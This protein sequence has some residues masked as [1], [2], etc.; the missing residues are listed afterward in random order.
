M[1]IIWRLWCNGNTT[2]CGT[3][4]LGSIPSSRPNRKKIPYLG[5][6]FLFRGG[7]YWELNVFLGTSDK[8]AHDCYY[9][10]HMKKTFIIIVVIIILGALWYFVSPLF[11]NKT[12]N[13][14]LDVDFITEME[15][16]T[17]E[18]I[19]VLSEEEKQDLE[20]KVIEEFSNVPDTVMEEDMPEMTGI[21]GSQPDILFS[22]GEFMDADSFH[23]ASGAA[24]LLRISG[25]LLLRFENFSVTNGPDL[26]VLL[27]TPEFAQGIGDDYIELEKLKGNKG[28]QNY[29]VPAGTDIDRYT[30]VVIY[31]KPFHVIFGTASL[32]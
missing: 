12:V 8:T 16:M 1:V 25:D 20:M 3:V 13:E 27:A 18:E 4:D 24:K 2:V 21:G 22:M 7:V 28:N 32:K 23:K 15:S 5:I 30:E 31:C 11:I 10:E 9:R 17:E 19:A 29:D 14:E 6:F 26:R